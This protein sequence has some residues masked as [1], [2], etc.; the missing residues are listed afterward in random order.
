MWANTGFNGR[1]GSTY[2]DSTPSWPEPV[3]GAG[4]PNVVF[5]VLDDM[6][7]G[8]LGCYD[9]RSLRRTSIDSQ[10]TASG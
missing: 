8:S 6:G 5:I 2:A 1:V 7:F 10:P 4:K 9:L 3:T